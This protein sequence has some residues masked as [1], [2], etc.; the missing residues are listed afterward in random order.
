[1][2]FDL[3][4][5]KPVSSAP[6]NGGF[7]LASAKPVTQQDDYEPLYQKYV[8]AYND[9]AN[10]VPI[11]GTPPVDQG[12]L[13]SKEQWRARNDQRWRNNLLSIPL[14]IGEQ[15]GNL[16]GGFVGAIPAVLGAGGKAIN[17]LSQGRDTSFEKDYSH[18]FGEASGIGTKLADMTGINTG[19]RKAISQGVGNFMNRVGIPMAGLNLPYINKNA[20]LR[21][22]MPE[23][24][25]Q[26]E[27]PRVPNKVLD[28]LDKQSGFDLSKAKRVDEKRKN[29]SEMTT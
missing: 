20:E 1:M 28:N 15:A 9:T 19:A 7:D 18:L 10:Q 27:V 24:A 3:S 23:L 12:P 29:Y 16:V 21:R 6:S 17:D 5:A 8:K 11:P 13:L 26:P 25:G 2:P 14:A 4:T 22:A